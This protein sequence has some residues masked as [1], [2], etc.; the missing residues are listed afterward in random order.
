MF[1]VQSRSDEIYGGRKPSAI[2]IV[3]DMVC[4]LPR[5]PYYVVSDIRVG[6]Q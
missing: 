4:R 1:V 6:R 3:T 2:G 5:L